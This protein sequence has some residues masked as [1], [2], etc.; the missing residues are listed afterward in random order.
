[1]S[2]LKRRDIMPEGGTGRVKGEDVLIMVRDNIL[3]TKVK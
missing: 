3:R 2:T 1:M